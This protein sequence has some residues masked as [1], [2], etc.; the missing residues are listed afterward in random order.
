MRDYR[1]M[2]M[3][4]NN[5]SPITTYTTIFRTPELPR[6]ACSCL[7]PIMF[8]C[9]LIPYTCAICVCTFS[10]EQRPWPKKGRC[11]FD[12]WRNWRRGTRSPTGKRLWWEARGGKRKQKMKNV[13]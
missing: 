13:R 3:V 5:E 10:A 7:G 8:I 11:P 1:Y 6:H 2:H 12:S 9:P 4:F